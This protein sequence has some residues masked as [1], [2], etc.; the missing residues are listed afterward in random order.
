MTELT[1]EDEQILALAKAKKEADRLSSRNMERIKFAAWSLWGL[2][3][4]IVAVSFFVFRVEWKLREFDHTFEVRNKR[5]EA[6]EI[7]RAEHER[8]TGLRD[9]RFNQQRRDL[10]ALIKEWS[11]RR[12]Q[13]DEMWW[14]KRQGLTNKDVQKP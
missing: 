10:D 13:I 9:E 1:A 8:I 2:G 6:L 3:F 5:T 14:M 12:A 7:W 11:D 4:L